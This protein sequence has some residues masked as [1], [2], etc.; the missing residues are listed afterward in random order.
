MGEPSSK[1]LDA[2][3]PSDGGLRKCYSSADDSS[4]MGRKLANL[5]DRDRYVA[6]LEDEETTGGGLALVGWGF[7]TVVACVLG[8]AS[9]Q[10]APPRS[11]ETEVARADASLP[12][13]SEV[14]GSIALA[15]RG[16]VQVTPSRVVGSAKVAPMP[17]ASNETVATSRDVEALRVEIKELQRRIAQM[18]ISGDGVS[19]RI[20]RLEEK[21]AGDA[22]TARERLAA[23]PPIPSAEPVRRVVE[24]EK[25]A[26]KP[27]DKAPERVAERVPLPPP[28]P[29]ADAPV[30]T[31][32][33]PPKAGEAPADT[34]A[35]PK[36]A[37][38]GAAAPIAVPPPAEAAVK[39]PTV[40]EP[41]KVE[42]ARVEPARVEA[43][44][45]APPAGEAVALDL[46]GYRTLASLKRSW[47]DMTTR[48][49][50][51]G[52]KM[53]PL[54]RLR[55]TDSGMEARLLAGPYASAAEATK[56]CQ[57]LKA[58]GVTCSVSSYSGQP[59]SGIK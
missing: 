36:A 26:E 7:T 14:T 44:A 22:A 46:G 54:A 29:L 28:R 49:G 17:L 2:T 1:G 34:V 37:R 57:R 47:S 18:G 20:D 13:P 21:M 10:Y 53:E 4:L 42:M 58:L 56:S 55:E 24:P 5:M 12:D 15:D 39:A 51:F 41:P 31:G 6:M 8:F 19:R 9:W 52:A 43:P 16:Q 11:I 25:A 45:A 38:A 48:Y 27:I 40:P 50:E 23:L 33:I 35:A 59:L 3:W 30:V 32:S